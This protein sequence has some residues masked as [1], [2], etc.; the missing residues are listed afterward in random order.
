MI[1]NTVRKSWL[2]VWVNYT[3]LNPSSLMEDLF[4]WQILS[5]F[6]YLGHTGAGIRHNKI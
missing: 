6:E 3:V 4:C 2:I 5:G 1:A